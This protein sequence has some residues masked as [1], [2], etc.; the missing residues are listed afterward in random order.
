MSFNV[1]QKFYDSVW[2]EFSGVPTLCG[3]VWV[4]Q[5]TY[6]QPFDGMQF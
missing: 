4:L 2:F 5:S 1:A 6:S 3:I